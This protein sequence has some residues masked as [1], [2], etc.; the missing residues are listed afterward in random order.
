MPAIKLLGSAMPEPMF[1]TTK[2]I[3]DMSAGEIRAAFVFYIGAGAVA[4]AG[5]IAL[6][7]SLPT[8]IGAFRAGFADMRASRL[9]QAVTARLRTDD[10][11]P[12]SVTVFGSIGLAIVLAFLPQIGVNLLGAILIILFGFFFTTVSSRICGQIGSSANPISVM[13]TASPITISFIFLPLGGNQIDDRVRTS[14]IPRCTKSA[15]SWTQAS[16]AAFTSTVGM[17]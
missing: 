12:I 4:S 6:A 1:G 16:A 14:S 5:I 2:L 10:D 17:S 3:R 9:G 7:R 13:T 11:L 15:T 8:I